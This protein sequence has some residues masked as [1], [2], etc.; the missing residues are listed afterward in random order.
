MFFFYFVISI[1]FHTFTLLFY[2]L[3]KT[4]NMNQRSSLQD[5][6]SK[7]SPSLTTMDD[8]NT[9]TAVVRWNYVRRL[10]PLPA[11]LNGVADI[12]P[13]LINL[14]EI[15]TPVLEFF[16]A[17][18]ECDSLCYNIFVSSQELSC[19]HKPF[20]YSSLTD[21][22]ASSGVSTLP[23][24][25]RSPTRVA[26]LSKESRYLYGS[27][28]A[29]VGDDNLPV[30]DFSHQIRATVALLTPWLKQSFPSTEFERLLFDFQKSL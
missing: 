24:N 27:L 1:S 4:R 7:E 3:H 8:T 18:I 17:C 21:S 11:F 13:G 23:G 6:D 26:A 20:S 28:F 15:K 29:L 9:L 12:H 2:S 19:R 22:S 5:S 16:L 14:Y 10:F 25:D 30:S